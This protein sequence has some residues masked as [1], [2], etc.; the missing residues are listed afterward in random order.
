MTSPLRRHVLRDASVVIT[1]MSS[2]ASIGSVLLS[3]WSALPGVL[4]WAGWAYIALTAAAGIYTLLTP[5]GIPAE[6]L[7]DQ[8]GFKRR[9]GLWLLALAAGLAVAALRLESVAVLIGLLGLGIAAYAVVYLYVL[10]RKYGPPKVK[11]CPDCEEDSKILARKCWKC[12]YLFPD[13][14]DG[15]MP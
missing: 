13:A 14:E 15:A 11:R 4:A 3:G 8:P 12:G 9:E 7:F 10:A 2:L 6:P 5:G 1:V